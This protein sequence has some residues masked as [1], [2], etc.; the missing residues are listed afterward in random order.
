MRQR[1]SK[2]AGG[3]RGRATPTLQERGHGGDE[4]LG[5]LLVRSGAIGFPVTESLEP[6]RAAKFL[7]WSC[8]R[9]CDIA[10]LLGESEATVSSWKRRDGW[11]VA[12]TL[13]RMEGIVEAR[14]IALVLKEQKD[15]RDFKEIDLL[16]RQAV[17]LAKIRRYEQPGGHSGHLNDKVAN[18]NAGEKKKP[19]RNVIT[20]E[21]LEILRQRHEDEMFGYQRDWHEVRD[22]RHRMILKSRQIGATF[23]FAREALITALETGKNQIFLSASKRQAHV[24][25]KYIVEFAKLTVGVDLTGEEILLDRG[26]DAD[27]GLPL[28]QPT[29]YFL[30][31]NSRTAQSNNGDLY[32][33]EFF[34]VHG[35]KTLEDVASGMASHKQF[36]LT[37]FST[38]SSI[39]DEAYPF[40]TGT[41]WNADRPKAD[42]VDID[43]SHKALKEGRLCADG[44]WRQIVTI[45]DAAAKGCTLFDLPSLRNRKSGAAWANLYMCQF[46]DDSMSVFPMAMLRKCFVDYDDWKDVHYDRQFLGYGRPYAGEVWL[47]YDP[48]GDGESADAAGL[49]LVAPPDVPGQGAFRVIWK[50]QF[51][52][53][54][55]TDQ[56]LRIKSLCERYNVTKI[57]IDETGLGKAVLQL[58][59]AW[60][61]QARGHRYDPEVKTRM[62]HK[63]L[64]VIAKGR[65]QYMID[66]SDLTSA[67]MSIR[68]TLTSKGRHLTYEAPR[69]RA[70][71]HGDLAWALFQA[72]D[73]EPLEASVGIVKRS[74]VK[75]ST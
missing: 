70:S 45:E 12:S 58:V 57:D 10:E 24:F 30:G 32:F 42:R 75:V 62:V 34:W 40:W 3:N 63:A 66:W 6:R 43:V 18:R 54:D 35:F 11:D 4:D 67:L 56:A 60:F 61:P 39:N 73:N 28:Q 48:N 59:K 49:V 37:Y 31:T 5:A 47:S 29:L 21:Q 22:Q 9:I 55:F 46:V 65:L 16:G 27:T 36:R 13:E 14:F 51:R 41:A 64:D 2:Q 17:T 38:P 50:E 8:W 53:S 20:E 26:E 69:T 44:I 7:Y 15:G 68:R 23:Y 19:R 74:R 1:P 33:D 25:R 52:G 72:L 71:G